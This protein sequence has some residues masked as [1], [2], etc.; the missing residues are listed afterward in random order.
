MA[1]ELWREEREFWLAGVAEAARRIDSACVMAFAQTGILDRAGVIAALQSAPRWQEVTMTARAT[2]ETDEVCLLAYH[3]TARRPGAETYRALCTT[4]WIR[5]A[6]D[7]RILQHQQ[8]P[9]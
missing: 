8:T 5:R 3:A 4:T 9:V 2:V 7:W 1:D 6:G